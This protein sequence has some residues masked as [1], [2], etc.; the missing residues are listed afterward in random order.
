MTVEVLCLQDDSATPR[1]ETIDGVKVFRV[2]VQKRRSGKVRYLFEYTSFLLAAAGFL[3][4]RCLRYGYDLIH[5]HNMPDF[6][7]FAALVPRILGTKVIL[8]MHDPM[9]ELHE[10]ITGRKHPRWLGELLKRIERLSLRF[11]DLVLTP[12]AAF[13]ELFL[14]RSC[15][16]G[17]LH[18]IMNSPEEEI[19][20]PNAFPGR[21]QPEGDVRRPFKLL[22]HGSLVERNGLDI[23]IEA[24]A[25]TRPYIANVTLLICGKR[26]KYLDASLALAKQKGL[27][28]RVCYLGPQSREGIARCIASSDLGLIPNRRSKFTELNMPTRIFECL[29]MGKPVIAPNTRGIRDYF[30]PGELLF[31]E[32]GNAEDLA[33][34]IQWSFHHPA[35]VDRIVERGRRIYQ[36]HLWSSE[37]ACYLSLVE[38]M[39][40]RNCG[41]QPRQSPGASLEPKD[42]GEQRDWSPEPNEASVPPV[43]K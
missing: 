15:Q 37:K 12:N 4:Y 28:D 26:T 3:S 9:P 10:S 27:G 8:D 22:Y 38:F 42:H 6:L 13:R 18:I 17:K 7:I 1:Q 32:L 24:V 5:V 40:N 11:A 31:F 20:H 14:S 19:Y 23:A 39:V 41:A 33:R 29:A 35:E 36:Q 25:L 16:P 30:G 43:E 2:P 34:K 21:S